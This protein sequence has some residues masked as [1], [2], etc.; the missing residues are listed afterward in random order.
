[1]TES[2]HTLRPL[3]APIKTPVKAHSGLPLE[4]E[5]AAAAVLSKLTSGTYAGTSDALAILKAE[6]ESLTSGD[7]QEIRNA[8]ARQIVLTEALSNH[9]AAAAAHTSSPEAASALSRTAINAQQAC[10][11]TLVALAALSEKPIS[12]A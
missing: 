11:R 12:S 8:L 3:A 10:M 5:A 9:F 4:G 2:L 1:M 7:P 6:V